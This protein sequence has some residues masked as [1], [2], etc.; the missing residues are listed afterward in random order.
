M[1]IT[2]EAVAILS[3]DE[4]REARQLAGLNLSTL[5]RYANISISQLCEF[6]NG[7]NGLRADQLQLCK[8]ILLGAVVERAERIQI[9]IAEQQKAAQTVALR[10]ANSGPISSTDR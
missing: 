7:L 8:E 5:A 4:M 10:Y 1:N 9:F 6:E 2:A 3:P